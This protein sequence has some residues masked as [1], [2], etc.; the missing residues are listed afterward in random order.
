MM[1][2]IRM[3]LYAIG[4]GLAGYGLGTYNGETGDLTINLFALEE[5]IYGVAIF[6]G[7]FLTSRIAKARGG[8]T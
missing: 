8:Q 1:L 2:L 6:A 3:V 5:V 7:T 4:A